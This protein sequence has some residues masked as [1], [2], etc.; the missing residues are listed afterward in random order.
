MKM[1]SG[2]QGAFAMNNR[3][4]V[5]SVSGGM[6]S[7]G[8]LLNLL[9]NKFKV[10]AISF[11][12]G[13]K[14]KIQLLNIQRNIV[15]L[16]RKLPQQLQIQWKKIDL[17]DAMQNFNSALTDSN[18]QVPCGHYQEQNMRITVVP[19]RNAIFSSII[20]G[21]ALSLATKYNYQKVDISLGVHSGD[22]CV[23]K[24][25]TPQFFTKLYSAFS[26]GNWQ[27]QRVSL[28]MPYIDKNKTYILQDSLNSCRVLGVQFD[29]ILSDT[30]TCYKPDSLGRSCGKCGSC[31]ERLQAFYNIGRKDP[32]QY[33]PIYS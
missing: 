30:I 22:H 27:S 17:S 4:A 5:I 2:V 25:T 26:Q 19:N 28:Y 31:S 15:K 7:T 20:Y 24:D 21:Y 18:I 13:Q 32:I 6:D 3:V 12:Y 29:N 8:L 16:N 1:V 23:Y 14:H 33:M 10:Y 11:Y 9:A